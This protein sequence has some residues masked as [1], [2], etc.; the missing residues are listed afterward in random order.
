[1]SF[2][3]PYYLTDPLVFLSLTLFATDSSAGSGSVVPVVR[4]H[5]CVEVLVSFTVH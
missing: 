5:T 4:E 3:S 1:M 2:I